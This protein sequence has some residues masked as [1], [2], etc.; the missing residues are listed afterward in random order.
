MK[1]IFKKLLNLSF[2]F[3]CFTSLSTH[4]MR[5]TPSVRLHRVTVRSTSTP[6]TINSQTRLVPRRSSVS[7]PS[8]MHQLQEINI[9]LRKARAKKIVARC[10]SIAWDAGGIAIVLPTVAAY[11][12]SGAGICAA[13]LSVPG[14]SPADCFDAQI[15]LLIMGAVHLTSRKALCAEEKLCDLIEKKCDENDD[16]VTEA[17]N[18]IEE[19]QKQRKA[20]ANKNL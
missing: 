7:M 4:S 3:A 2:M 6:L 1:K 17:K 11:Y 12:F 18:L 8:P 13:L 10:K 9:Q 16:K 5:R 14:L 20:L 15:P 19:L